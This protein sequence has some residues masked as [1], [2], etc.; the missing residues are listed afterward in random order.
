[1]KRKRNDVLGTVNRG[2]PAPSGL[3]TLCESG[4]KGKCET[5][6]SSLYGTKM[7][8][9]RDF[10]SVTAGSANLDPR[11]TGYHSLRI[12]GYSFGAEGLDDELERTPKNCIYENVNIESEFGSEM[13]SSCKVPVMTGALGSTFIAEK[14]WES[15]AIGA[16]LTGFPIV[17][18]ENVVGVDREAEMNNGRIVSAPELDRRIEI[19]QRYR[20][21]DYGDIF[22][23]LNQEDFSN[24]VAEYIW[25][26]YGNEVV[27]ELKWGQGAKSIGGEIQVESLEYAE[28][29][30]ERGYIV[31]PDPTREAT[32]KAFEAGTIDSF[33]RHSRLGGTGVDN[34]AEMREAFMEKVDYL[35]ELGFD[36]ISLKTGAFGMRGLAMALRLSAEAG[37]ELL[38]IDG[39]GGGTGMSPWNMMDHWGVPSLPLH[40]K[41]VEYADLLA[42]EGMD[43]PDLALAGGLSREDHMF[44]ALALGSPH[45]KLI[46]MGRTLMIPGFLGAN[47]EGVFHPERREELNGNWESL[48]STVKEAGETPEAIFA[49]WYDVEDKVG[50][51][52][53]KEIP[54]GAVAIH[55]LMDK[56]GTGL[57]QFMAGVRKFNISAL[58][59]TDLMAA[60]KKTAELTGI[61]Y[62]IEAQDESAREIIKGSF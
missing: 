54:Y 18:G 31:D 21:E 36:R 5:W 48:P 39:A 16:A 40:V 37:L 33:A 50:S 45:V 42:D 6:M 62:L 2:D 56:L 27:I 12:Q 19:Y 60:N 17:I 34:K 9:P 25:E 55:T 13:K 22:I 35:R 51:E 57:Q 11:G 52:Q 1:M 53:M 4:C 38:T 15:F 23:Q 30:H 7:L 14:Y 3:C 28:F 20:Q 43:V 46:C 8:Y 24:G 29:L 49:G 44:K 10:G 58:E 26:E 41:A 32:R 61:P 59:R 47:I